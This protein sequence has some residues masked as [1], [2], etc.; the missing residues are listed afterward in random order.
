LALV[1]LELTVGASKS[2]CACA[3]E[4]SAVAGAVACVQTRVWIARVD[5]G[6]AVGASHT[7]HVII[8]HYLINP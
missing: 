2:N 8:N 7:C 1:D 6:A 4:E 5:N 3:V